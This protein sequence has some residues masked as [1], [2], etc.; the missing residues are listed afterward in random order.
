LSTYVLNFAVNDTG[1]WRFAAVEDNIIPLV[2]RRVI[3]HV[4]FQQLVY[5]VE[6]AV[7]E[8]EMSVHPLPVSFVAGSDQRHSNAQCDATK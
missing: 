6:L 7:P 8:V 4:L 3:P 2:P 1:I 5:I